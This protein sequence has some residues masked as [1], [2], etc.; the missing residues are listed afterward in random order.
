M[1]DYWGYIGSGSSEGNLQG[2]FCGR[3]VLKKKYGQTPKFFTSTAS[4]YSLIKYSKLLDLDT[5]FLP[6]NSYDEIDIENMRKE[7]SN[8]D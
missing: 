5:S 3:E 4:H 7:I 1:N 2:L 8:L 6:V